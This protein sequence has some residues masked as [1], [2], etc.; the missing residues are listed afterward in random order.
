[1][2]VDV[3]LHPD[4]WEI[5]H[6]GYCWWVCMS[7]VNVNNETP[8]WLILTSFWIRKCVDTIWPFLVWFTNFGPLVGCLPIV[9][10]RPMCALLSASSEASLSMSS[11]KVIASVLQRWRSLVWIPEFACCRCACM[12]FP[13]VLWVP[14]HSKDMLVG[15][16]LSVGGF[17]WGC[18]C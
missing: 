16:L 14:P 18:F 15:I 4:W 10:N 2:G 11:T 8:S 9:G 5:F 12:G 7:R 6:A 1:M 17:F 3:I 13:R